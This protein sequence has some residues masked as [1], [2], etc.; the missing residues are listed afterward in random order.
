[1]TLAYT[2]PEI[3]NVKMS[4]MSYHV[5]AGTWSSCAWPFGDPYDFLYFP[6]LDAF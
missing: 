2:S 1:V 3:P 6:R 4:Y 5:V